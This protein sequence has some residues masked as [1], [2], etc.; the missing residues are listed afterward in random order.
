MPGDP[1]GDRM[2]TAVLLCEEEVQIASYL[3]S[4]LHLSSLSTHFAP[5][6]HPAAASG[7]YPP[8]SIQC[9]QSSCLR[10]CF[11]LLVAGPMRSVSIFLSHYTKKQC[12]ALSGIDK[13]AEN[14]IAEWLHNKGDDRLK[15]KGELLP[16][17]HQDLSRTLGVHH[18]YVHSKIMADNN[19]KPESLQRRIDMDAAWDKLKVEIQEA[20]CNCNMTIGEFVRDQTTIDMFKDEI[21]RLDKMAKSCNDAIISDS[22]R[23]NGRSPV[24]HARRFD[25]E[26]RMREAV[27]D[28]S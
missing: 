20:Y 26:E 21:K 28:S 10:W 13:V 9:L 17:R 1:A 15:K 25:F 19:I 23:F 12:R 16:D 8:L 5:H 7:A 3:L 4:P 18:D 14:K 11:Y 22:M 6:P 27:D 24:R 2:E